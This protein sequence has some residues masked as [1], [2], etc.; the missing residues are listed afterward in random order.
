MPCAVI[1]A[2]IDLQIVDVAALYQDEIRRSFDA[3]S[4]AAAGGPS[5]PRVV[6]VL[7]LSGDNG[8]IQQARSHGVPAVRIG[9]AAEALGA[10]VDGAAPLTASRLRAALAQNA[11]AGAARRRRGRKRCMHAV[12]VDRQSLAL[13]LTSVLCVL[14]FLR[15]QGPTTERRER[16]VCRKN[17]TL[18]S[19]AYGSRRRLSLRAQ[20][21]LA[22]AL[23]ARCPKPQ[24]TRPP[25][26][27]TRVMTLDAERAMRCAIAEGMIAIGSRPADRIEQLR[28][29][30][31]D[32]GAGADPSAV[33]ARI[34]S[35]LSAPAPA[36]APLLLSPAPSAD[37]DTLAAEGGCGGAF[38]PG[39][40]DAAAAAGIDFE[41]AN[42]QGLLRVLQRRLEQ[43]EGIVRTL[44]SPS[45]V[46]RWAATPPAPSADGGPSSSG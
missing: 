19:P 23:H 13:K 3:A 39:G 27:H 5:T 33:L 40:E 28:A 35:L 31:E 18:P 15:L 17:S 32:E 37:A 12:A 24:R 34:R 6:P 45:R 9:D 2:Q 16:P 10:L 41:S 46:L 26:D 4:A 8:Q 36:P 38:S 22:H 7:L 21:C 11:L 25:H 42:N 14:C 29:L 44:E 20:V 30:A 43:W 1:A